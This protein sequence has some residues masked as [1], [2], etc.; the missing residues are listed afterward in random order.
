MVNTQTKELLPM[1]MNVHFFSTRNIFLKLMTALLFCAS[2]SLMAPAFA[3][4]TQA[5]APVSVATGKININTADAAT[6]AATMNGV[7]IKK[8]EAII[9]YREAYGPF[10]DIQELVDVK[11]IGPATLQKNAHLISVE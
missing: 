4:G 5:S 11:G 1:F 6:L 10:A 2:F 7:G 9:A 8:A 3:E